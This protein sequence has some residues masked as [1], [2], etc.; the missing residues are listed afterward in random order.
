MQSCLVRSSMARSWEV[1]RKK[2]SQCTD[3]RHTSW[4]FP[5]MSKGVKRSAPPSKVFTVC[6]LHLRAISSM[7]T[8]PVQEAK[9]RRQTQ[10]RCPSAYK[11]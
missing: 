11:T 1:R 10:E 4:T 2:R 8:G 7:Y 5:A 9:D 3:P 6:T